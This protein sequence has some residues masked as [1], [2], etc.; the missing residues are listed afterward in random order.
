MI[1]Y[2]A[3]KTLFNSDLQPINIYTFPLHQPAAV[4]SP[5]VSSIC[6][7]VILLLIAQ[8]FPEFPRRVYYLMVFPWCFLFG[9]DA[10]LQS[11]TL[12]KLKKLS[13]CILYVAAEHTHLNL[14]KCSAS[15]IIKANLIQKVGTRMPRLNI[16]FFVVSGAILNQLIRL[17]ILYRVLEE[18]GA[19]VRQRRTSITLQ[20]K[21]HTFAHAVIVCIPNPLLALIVLFQ[22]VVIEPEIDVLAESQLYFADVNMRNLINL[23]TLTN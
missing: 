21:F 16:L 14:S 1:D 7:S 17:T 23:L 22:H 12:L 3:L 2:F 9:C 5:I 19:Q 10:L 20:N 18:Y 8:K 15:I 11:F 4:L 6:V 13:F